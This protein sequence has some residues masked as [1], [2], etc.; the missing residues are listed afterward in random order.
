MPSIL[1]GRVGREGGCTYQVTGEG[2]DMASSLV[3]QPGFKFPA[4]CPIATPVVFVG[5]VLAGQDGDDLT[6]M[7]VRVWGMAGRDNNNDDKSRETWALTCLPMARVFT[8][9]LGKAAICA[10]TWGKTCL[11]KHACNCW[12]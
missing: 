10:S 8:L 7:Y 2:L 6:T 5:E 4:D 1:W 12:S 9:S 3:C 11:A